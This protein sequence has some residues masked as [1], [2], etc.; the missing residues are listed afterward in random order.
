MYIKYNYLINYCY[1]KKNTMNWELSFFF[2]NLKKE[3]KKQKKKL[4][5]K[6]K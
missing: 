6:I 5:A 4:K 1:D 3:I 2:K